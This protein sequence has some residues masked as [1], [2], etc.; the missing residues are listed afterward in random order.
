MDP[1]LILVIAIVVLFYVRIWYLRRRRQR[2][3]RKAVL[4]QMK[5]GRK[6]GKLP[7]KDPDELSIHI[8]SWWILV[9]AMLIMLLGLAVFT[10]AFLSDWKAYW[11]IPTAIGGIMFIFSFD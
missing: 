2:M 11:W 3:E 4:S 9:P 7:E 6:A 8:R 1:A 5:Q 10:E